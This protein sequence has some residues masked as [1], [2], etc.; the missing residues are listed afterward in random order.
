MQVVDKLFPMIASLCQRNLQEID[1]LPLVGIHHIQTV[2]VNL[3]TVHEYHLGI[4]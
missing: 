3:N 2:V 1:S 4:K